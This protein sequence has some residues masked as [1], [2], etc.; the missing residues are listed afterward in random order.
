MQA[1]AE[2]LQDAPRFS[3]G[4][5]V[6]RPAA[7]EYGRFWNATNTDT[8]GGLYFDNG[9]VW[10]RVTPSPWVTW[11]PTMRITNGGGANSPS[12]S[13]SFTTVGYGGFRYRVLP[14]SSVE[15]DAEALVT[16]SG[17][18]VFC[19]VVLSTPVSS[20]RTTVLASEF[21]ND[22][23]RCEVT[24]YYPGNSF[25]LFPPTGYSAGEWQFNNAGIYMGRWH[26]GGAA[27]VLRIHGIY[28][29]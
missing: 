17:S 9:V 24:D 16:L 5:L 15:V 19:G 28:P 23:A 18:Y 26:V 3:Q 7:G 1:L 27:T 29:V 2:S 20:A 13:G 11:T 8:N 14:G 21:Q 6:D 25:V 4:A 10:S 12:V 22:V